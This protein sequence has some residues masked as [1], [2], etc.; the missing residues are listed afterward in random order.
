MVIIAFGG[1]LLILVSRVLRILNQDPNGPA[2]NTTCKFNPHPHHP[3]SQPDAGTGSV[4]CGIQLDPNEHPRMTPEV[5]R[6]VG[7]PLGYRVR[8]TESRPEATKVVDCSRG[9]HTAA[10]HN[11]TQI[12]GETAVQHCNE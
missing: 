9:S 10:A 5:R 3:P 1:S 6:A 7:P 11:P 12:D 4:A 2:G 8:G